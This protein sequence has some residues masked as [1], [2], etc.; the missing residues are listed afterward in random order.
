MFQKLNI[1]NKLALIMITFSVV[2]TAFLAASFYLQFDEALR[3]RV[4]LQLSSVKSLK[5]T[6]IKA[7]IEDKVKAYE[8]HISSE[9]VLDTT[10]IKVP[11]KLLGYSLDQVKPSGT[12][13]HLIDLTP[14][15]PLK[16]MTVAFAQRRSKD[17][18][19]LA[20]VNLPEIQ[21]ILLE[22]TGLGETGESYLVS[23]NRN[24]IS[25]SRFGNKEYPIIVKTKGVQEALEGRPG[26]DTFLDYR[27]IEVFG[28][29]EEIEILGLN[30]VLLSEINLEEALSPLGQVQG[31]L[32]FTVLIILLFILIVSYFLSKLIVQPIVSMKRQLK[33]MS[34]GFIE[35]D[36]SNAERQDEIGDM[37]E[38]LNKLVA[39]MTETI[40]LAGE[41][42]SGNFTADYQMLSKN[43]RMG[44]ALIKMKERLQ[45]Y[46]ENEDRLVKE[47][48]YSIINGEENERSRLSKE[49]HDGLGPLLTTL[50]MNLQSTSLEDKTKDQLL[51]QLDETIKEVRRISN[52]LMPSVLSDFGAG[53]ALGNLIEQVSEH[54]DISI[55]YRHDMKSKST[56]NSK[57]H[58]SLYRIVQEAL[59]NAL[60]HATCKEIKISISEFDDH[61]GLYIAD[62]GDGF[63]P[64][65]SH[66]GN[67]LRNMKERVKLV[68]GSFEI[69]SS[70]T[71]G[72]T[73]IEI[74]IPIV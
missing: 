1:G 24:L 56:I 34:Q 45:A 46:K 41:I 26:T 69:K 13:L 70:E 22:R 42:G 62:D 31:H 5:L 48:Q 2:I 33:R 38:A 23:A 7:E 17:S 51:S 21:E 68:N 63:D 50:R 14:Q 19:R 29:Y 25:Q 54:T 55:L 8:D 39:A 61:I 65:Q 28:A 18:I 53:E 16:G 40:H 27:G 6:K 32:M 58:L 44:K 71:G 4:L 11:S 30:W 64:S 73:T 15:N 67:G 43:D 66:S 20:I 35:P 52:N 57:I 60:K 37:F 9:F 74:E 47:N 59:N 49:L 36:S 72:G 12:E 3:E 10:I